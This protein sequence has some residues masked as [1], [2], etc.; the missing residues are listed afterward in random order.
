ME[1]TEPDGAVLFV[2]K[3]GSELHWIGPPTEVYDYATGTLVGRVGAQRSFHAV[4]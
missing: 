2:L 4:S 3:D 1:L